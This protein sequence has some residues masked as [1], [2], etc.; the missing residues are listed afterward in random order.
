MSS[1]N[2]VVTHF[3]DEPTNTYSYVVQDPESK[4]CAIIDSVLDFDYAAGRTNTESA[5]A[6]LAFVK[7]K[8]L[9]EPPQK[10]LLAISGGIDSMVLLHLF[11]KRHRLRL[12]THQHAAQFSAPSQ[13]RISAG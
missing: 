5:E 1:Q 4:H 2:P 11:E 3:F 7:E 8:Q 9:F 13:Y 6:I 12:H 10:V